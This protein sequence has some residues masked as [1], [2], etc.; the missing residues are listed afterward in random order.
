MKQNRILV[1]GAFGYVGQN[2][3]P[4][5][6][7][8]GY[9]VICIDR[10]IGAEV[11]SIDAKGLIDMEI[12]HVIH[13]AGQSG[14]KNCDEN[15][16]QAYSDN[17]KSTINLF[18]EMSKAG[19]NGTFASSQAAKTPTANYYGLTK[20]FGEIE[21]RSQYLKYGTN[22]NVLRFTNIYGGIGFLET[23][24]TVVCKFAKAKKNNETIVVNG[25]GDQE[26]DFI[27]INDICNAIWRSIL[28]STQTPIDIGTGVATSVRRLVDYFRHKFT[29]DDKSGMIG[30]MRNVAD[31]IDAYTYLGFK[32]EIDLEDQIRKEFF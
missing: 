6:R 31:P 19:V 32:A 1:T 25:Y 3:Q 12:S 26:R 30:T 15:L 29:Y 13:L 9:E 2:L 21:A 4:F 28:F 23:K 8:K 5:L 7:N 27:H 22:I 10:K 11:L 14:L 20:Y 17:I 24:N 18:T 16:E